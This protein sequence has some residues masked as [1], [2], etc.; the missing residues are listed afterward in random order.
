VS[1]KQ[2][3]S[4][5]NI[6]IQELRRI[7]EAS[8]AKYGAKA[9]NMRAKILT[10]QESKDLLITKENKKLQRATEENATLQLQVEEFKAKAADE[11]RLVRHMIGELATAAR[12]AIATD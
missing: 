3:S 10:S 8:L 4:T 11:H 2:H 12:K 9:A 1:T 7:K 5:K 6:E